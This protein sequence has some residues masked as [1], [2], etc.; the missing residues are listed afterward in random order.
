MSGPN[1]TTTG[2]QLRRAFDEAFAVAPLPDRAPGENLLLLRVQRID[3]AVRLNEVAAVSRCPPLTPLP[4]QNPSVLGLVGL[5][6]GLVVVH[7]FAALVGEPRS[8]LDDRAIL[9]LCAGEPAVGL[10]A[11]ELLGHFHA[12]AS[13]IHTDPVQGSWSNAIVSGGDRRCPLASI[14]LL[15]A[16][17][18]RAASAERRGDET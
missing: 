3:V 5:R 10:L 11:D 7:S 9:L 8:K 12:E 16:V 13:T 15:L 14:P 18:R 17:I 2:A 1:A 4:S 6:G